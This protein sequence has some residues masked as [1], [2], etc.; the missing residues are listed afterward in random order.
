MTQNLSMSIEPSDPTEFID[1]V[2]E[3]FIEGNVLLFISVVKSGF[4]LFL[5]IVLKID[6][7]L[8]ILYM[9]IF[10]SS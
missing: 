9:S 3:L 2:G 8:G 4:D 1:P 10:Y 5:I 6:D 7:G